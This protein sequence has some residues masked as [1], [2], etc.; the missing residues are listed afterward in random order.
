MLKTIIWIIFFPPIHHPPLPLA[1]VMREN[2]KFV[3]FEATVFALF[4]LDQISLQ[5]KN[6]SQ[7]VE[8]IFF[9]ML[10]EFEGNCRGNSNGK[11]SQF[12]WTIH[13]LLIS[14]YF[15]LSLHYWDKLDVIAEHSDSRTD[16]TLYLQTTSST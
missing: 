7:H 8:K 3:F 1:L 4:F 11:Y 10:C 9:L 5:K 14:H 2:K 12:F 13:S 6:F 15:F 16:A